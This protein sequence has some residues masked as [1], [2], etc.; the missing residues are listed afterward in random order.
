MEILASKGGLT[1]DSTRERNNPYTFFSHS[2]IYLGFEELLL[3]ACVH[4]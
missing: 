1:E 2:G 3:R 4:E